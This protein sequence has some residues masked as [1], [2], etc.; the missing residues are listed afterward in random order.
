MAVVF[1]AVAIFPE[2]KWRK[3][4]WEFS[5]GG[6]KRLKAASGVFSL[7]LLQSTNALIFVRTET[8]TTITEA[9]GILVLRNR[10]LSVSSAL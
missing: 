6:G 9:E 2:I 10:V 1:G 4:F 3:V 8:P 7:I 5:F